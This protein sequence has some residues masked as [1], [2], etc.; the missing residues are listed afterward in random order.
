MKTFE[1]TITYK[2]S[3]VTKFTTE[4]SQEFGAKTLEKEKER[5]ENLGHKY[6]YKMVD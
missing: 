5:F 3:G 6:E 4:L 2:L 1:I